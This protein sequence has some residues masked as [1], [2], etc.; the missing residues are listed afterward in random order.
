LQDIYLNLDASLLPHQV[1][2]F[3]Q[4]ALKISTSPGQ[5]INT[6]KSTPSKSEHSIVFI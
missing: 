6:E 1:T 2:N 4:A 5:N 3:I